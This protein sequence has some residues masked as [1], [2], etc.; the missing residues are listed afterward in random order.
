LKQIQQD[1]ALAVVCI[2]VD[3]DIV[4]IIMTIE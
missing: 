3:D 2:A 4:V 1:V